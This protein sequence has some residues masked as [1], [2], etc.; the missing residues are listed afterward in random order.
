VTVENYGIV[1]DP[2][3]QKYRDDMARLDKVINRKA[4][5]AEEH[6]RKSAAGYKSPLTAKQKRAKEKKR[7]RKNGGPR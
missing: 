4:H 5:E 7:K 1:G 2:E 3:F 6:R